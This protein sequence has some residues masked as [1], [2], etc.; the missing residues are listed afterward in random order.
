MIGYMKVDEAARRWSISKRQ[1]QYLCTHGR[2]N[3]T[4]KFGNTWAIPEDVEKP[5]RTGTIKP[6]RKTAQ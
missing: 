6:G 5:T 1:V 3:G 4:E 2:I